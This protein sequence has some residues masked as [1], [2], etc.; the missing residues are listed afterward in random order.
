M[1]MQEQKSGA[2]DVKIESMRILK[3]V[4][5]LKLLRALRF[6][7]RLN[8]LEQKEGFAVFKKALRIGKSGVCTSDE[9]RRQSSSVRLLY[10]Q[11]R[12][13]VSRWGKQEG[14][15]V[16]KKT[17]GTSKSGVCQG[18]VYQMK[19]QGRFRLS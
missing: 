1:D 13:V 12:C 18:C 10:Q 4:R 5:M 19:T 17:L 14:F 2:V 6:M 15:A 11:I 3:V 7:D 9:N 16:F 8:R